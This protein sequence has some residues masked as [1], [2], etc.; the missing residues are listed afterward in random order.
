MGLHQGRPPGYSQPAVGTYPSGA[1]S[2]LTIL[3]SEKKF[4]IFVK[5]FGS[6]A[7][8]LSPGHRLFIITTEKFCRFMGMSLWFQSTIDWEY[9]DFYT[10]ETTEWRMVQ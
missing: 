2:Y 7:E 4:L 3:T 5:R 10:L 9:L 6:T 8:G 1:Q